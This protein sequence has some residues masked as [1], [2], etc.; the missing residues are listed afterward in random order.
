MHSTSTVPTNSDGKGIQN[1]YRYSVYRTFAN[2][3][4]ID[5]ILRSKPIFN[6]YELAA[7][8]AIDVVK[9][10]SDKNI[11]KHSGG[12]GVGGDVYYRIEVI[13]ESIALRV[14]NYEDYIDQID[15]LVRAA[16]QQGLNLLSDEL[17]DCAVCHENS[18]PAC[19]VHIVNAVR[20]LD[21]ES[22]YGCS[23]TLKPR[24]RPKYYDDSYDYLICGYTS[25]WLRKC[26]T[27]KL[28]QKLLVLECA[29]HGI[30]V[31]PKPNNKIDNPFMQCDSCADSGPIR[32][33]SRKSREYD[34][35]SEPDT[36]SP[37]L[38]GTDADTPCDSAS[39]MSDVESNTESI[40]EICDEIGLLDVREV[41][42]CN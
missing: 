29:A 3:L 26:S 38:T 42:Q 40:I 10:E 27:V 39:S 5:R 22:V 8:R 7:L 18:E 33:K 6:S 21:A 32:R 25:D 4:H 36:D 12:V 30:K 20:N 9:A 37:A 23:Q 17:V 13:D 35:V 11:E 2:E 41:K 34:S 28:L 16:K 24:Y 31:T 14:D 19:Y 15:Y 1:K